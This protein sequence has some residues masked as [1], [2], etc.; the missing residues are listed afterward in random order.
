MHTQLHLLYAASANEEE[1]DDAVVAAVVITIT[2]L[3]Y[4]YF[5]IAYVVRFWCCEMPFNFLINTVFWCVY[6]QSQ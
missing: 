4:H 1:D 3:Y 6:C 2:T 5:C